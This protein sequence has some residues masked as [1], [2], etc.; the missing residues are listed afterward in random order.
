MGAAAEPGVAAVER[1]LSLLAAWREG[2]AALSLAELAARTG[3]YKSTIL[4]LL[5]SLERFRCVQRR[6]DGQWALG[7]MLFRWGMLYQRGLRLDAIL[8]PALRR[9]A[10]ETG[11]SATF[12]VREG[13]QR[14][15]LFR[16]DSPR[17][18]RDHLL[19]G[20]LLPLEQ[21]AGGRV[22]LAFAAG[23]PP[24]GMDPVVVTLGERDPDMAAL[25]APVFGGGGALAGALALSGPRARLAPLAE[26]LKPALAAA[27]AALTRRLGG[28][29]G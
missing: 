26:G 24:P 21:G 1:A 25:A 8:P 16:A 17:A 23:P 19:P 13:G 4:R 18:V 7:P 15:C 6:P 11:E 3:L 2:E 14:L 12:W 29:L 20:E 28:D 9:L 5:A 27:A 10:D 22:L